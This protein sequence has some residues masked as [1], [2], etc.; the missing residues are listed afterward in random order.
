MA[1]VRELV[2]RRVWEYM[3][4]KRGTGRDFTAIRRGPRGR[5]RRELAP[6]AM[7]FA[8]AAGPVSGLADRVVRVR[9]ESQRDPQ[10]VGVLLS[11]RLVLTVGDAAQNPRPSDFAWVRVED[12]E[13]L[14]RQAWGDGGSP[15]VLLLVSE[16]D[17]ADS[18]DRAEPAWA[19]GFAAPGEHLVVDGATDQGEAVALAAE[20]LP[21]EGERNG[22]LVR[23]SAEPE[24]W[25]H[26][27]GSP[28]SRDGL[29]AG[30][31]HS[32]LPDRMVFLTGQA[33]LEQ[34]GFRAV[35]AAHA[36][37][38]R[39]RSGV[40]MAVRIQVEQGPADRSATEEVT[41]I[42]LRAQTGAGG[43]GSVFSA[44]DG[45]LFVPLEDPGALARA[46]RLL[47]ALPRRW[48]GCAR[49]PANGRSPWWW[50]WPEDGSRPICGDRRRTRPGRWPTARSAPGGRP[51]PGTRQRSSS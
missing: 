34:P 19:E 37:T 14:C 45:A 21:Y 36:G 46:G 6:G 42:L 48:S 3:S 33:L 39:E 13:F 4:H 15:Q 26:Y 38:G 24:A 28:V 50:L 31:V 8:L 43:A 11:P 18:A 23:L 29:L 41:Q 40:C 10:A 47:A 17:L 1:A 35:V 12:Q 49:A 2:R 22:E 5:G 20:V 7:P 27:T 16:V 51:V 44:G 25:T 9:Y 32:V 30:I